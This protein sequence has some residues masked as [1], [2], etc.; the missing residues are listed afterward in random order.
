MSE[1]VVEVESRVDSV[2]K[3]LA[4]QNDRIAELESMNARL[5]EQ[6]SGLHAKVD[7][8]TDL[9]GRSG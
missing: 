4:R 8:L 3:R 5:L 1:L 2:E 7:T 6:L 9:L